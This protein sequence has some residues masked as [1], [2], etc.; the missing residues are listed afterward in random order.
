MNNKFQEYAVSQEYIF[1]TMSLKVKIILTS[2]TK[3]ARISTRQQKYK[4]LEADMANAQF[5]T[6]QEKV[7]LY[8]TKKP[9]MDRKFVTDSKIEEVQYT[10][11]LTT[12]MSLCRM[13]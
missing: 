5:A 10:E 11:K 8:F 12:E 2:Q 9:H 6:V 3:Q 7:L 4:M 13:P 1:P